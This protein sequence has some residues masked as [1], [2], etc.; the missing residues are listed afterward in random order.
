MSADNVVPMAL[1]QMEHL[2]SL[3][4]TNGQYAERVKELLQRCRSV[5]LDK[6]ALVIGWRKNDTASLMA[7]SAG[8]QSIALLSMCL[9]NLFTP[10]DV[11]AI[12]SHL[13]SQ[14]CS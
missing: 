13:C 9:V 14:L 4:P 5:R 3:L 1:L 6:L 10:R 12:L 2:G 7:Q 11:G 8:G